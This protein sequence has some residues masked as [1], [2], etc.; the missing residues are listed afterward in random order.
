MKMQEI[1]SK[2]DYTILDRCAT[3]SDVKEVIDDGI[4]YNVASVCI[5][6]CFV[7]QAKRYADGRIKIC[8]VIGFPNGYN[9]TKAKLCEAKE[10]IENGADEIDAVINT[11]ELKAQNYDYLLNEIIELKKVCGDKILKIIIET[12]LLSDNE[13]A[14]MCDI[15]R[16]GGADYIKTSTGFSSGGAK[17]EDIA[18]MYSKLKGSVLIKASGGIKTPSDAEDF[19]RLGADRIGTS[20]IIKA[21]KAID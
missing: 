14:K 5:P 9:T 18:L 7:E 8:T 6:P 10:A 16:Q 2:C 17:R 13:K 19:I 15:V 12:C 3:W 20:G 4:I 1:L 21:I 11:G